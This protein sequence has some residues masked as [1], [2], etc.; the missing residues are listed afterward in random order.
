MARVE[1]GTTPSGKRRRGHAGY[2]VACLP[3]VDVKVDDGE[4]VSLCNN[5]DS[6]GYYPE[7]CN[8]SRT[9]GYRRST[10]H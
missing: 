8:V 6:I 5:N 9:G 7:M 3:V 2:C 10:S 1:C 4:L